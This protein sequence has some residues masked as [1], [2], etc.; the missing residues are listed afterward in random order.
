MV[1]SR[2]QIQGKA[3]ARAELKLGPHVASVLRL[4]IVILYAHMYMLTGHFTVA[5]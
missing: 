1:V 2:Q 5:L 3:A 4:S